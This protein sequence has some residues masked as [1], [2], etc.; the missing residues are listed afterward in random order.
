M[1]I[2]HNMKGMLKNQLEFFQKTKTIRALS[3]N[4]NQSYKNKMTAYDKKEF[5]DESY[6]NYQIEYLEIRSFPHNSH[7]LHFDA[8]KSITENIKFQLH[9]YTFSHKHI[10]PHSTHFIVKS[11][12]DFDAILEVLELLNKETYIHYSFYK[13]IMNDFFPERPIKKAKIEIPAFMEGIGNAFVFSGKTPQGKPLE[14]SGPSY[15]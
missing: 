8:P 2:L 10:R 12:G 9:Y 7:E 4:Y 6:N 13:D 14:K 1:N 5:H 15:S 3:N 11:E